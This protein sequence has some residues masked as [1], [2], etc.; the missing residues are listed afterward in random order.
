MVT[1][2]GRKVP[3]MLPTVLKAPRVPTIFPL[4]SRLS[5]VYLTREGVTVPRRNRGK[6]KITMQVRNAAQI[7]RLLFTVKTSRAEMPRIMYFPPKESPRST[8]PR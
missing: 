7:S 6:T 4:S 1:K 5:M 2:V 3:M 8:P